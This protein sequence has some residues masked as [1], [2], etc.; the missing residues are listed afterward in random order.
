MART[1]F[2]FLYGQVRGTNV[3]DFDLGEGADV[4]LSFKSP[5]SP[6]SDGILV[7]KVDVVVGNGER[8]VGH[9][10][11]HQVGGLVTGGNRGAPTM[12]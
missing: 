8:E 11:T 6:S 5:Q 10:D 2:K 4:L 3:W 1:E 12:V 7:T 9:R